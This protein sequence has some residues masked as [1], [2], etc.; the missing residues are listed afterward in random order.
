M[1]IAYF[2]MEFSNL[3]ADIGRI[4]C[5]SIYTYPSSRMVTYRIDEVNNG[6][7]LH[8]DGKIAKLI[9]DKLDAHDL[10]VTWYGKM[11]DMP[12]LN[13]R[14]A[15]A[16]LDPVK[17]RFHLDLRWKASGPYGI[18]PRNAKLS[19]VA[20][21]FGF[22]DQKMIVPVEIWVRAQAGDKEA[23]DILCERC[24]SDVMLTYQAYWKLLPFVARLE[25]FGN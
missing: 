14:L 9:R 1:R 12:F 6:K 15:A 16:E 25:R 17:R 13:T 18:N 8:Y 3:K 22:Q 5:G 4:I 7:D 24:E 21:F 2:D 20:E 23:I 19:T 10:I 11:C